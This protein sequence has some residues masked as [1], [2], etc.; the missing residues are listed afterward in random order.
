VIVLKK[1]GET[2]SADGTHLGHSLP[3]R[4]EHC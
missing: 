1:L 3:Y 4:R 2:V